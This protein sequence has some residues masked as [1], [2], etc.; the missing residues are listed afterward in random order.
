MVASI[1]SEEGCWWN[2]R[3][4]FDYWILT[5]ECELDCAARGENGYGGCDHSAPSM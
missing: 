2:T 4:Q 3:W 1:I 5:V